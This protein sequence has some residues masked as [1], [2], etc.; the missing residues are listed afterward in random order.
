VKENTNVRPRNPADGFLLVVEGIDG[1]G[2]TTLT[3]AL[4]DAFREEGYQV[5]LTREPTDG[6]YGRRLRGLTPEERAKM[7]PEQELALF[8][9]DR[10]QHVR[11]SVMPALKAGQLVIQ[12][13]SYFSTAAYQAER[14]LDPAKLLAD[15]ASM[16]PV[17]D[18]WILVDVPPE[19]AILRIEHSRGSKP[20]AFESRSQLERVRCRFLSFPGA[21]VLDGRLAPGPLL[22][23]ALRE[24]RLRLPSAPGKRE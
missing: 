2:K 19:E 6:R 15:G 20:D 10:K 21:L 17:P 11:E 16:A 4:A 22:Q 18:L 23:A 13:R 1:S 8:V 24:V 12:D 3:R 5:L 14:G 9:E 7:S